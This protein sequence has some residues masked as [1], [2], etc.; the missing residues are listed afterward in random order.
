MAKQRLSMPEKKIVPWKKVVP[1]T[2][3][4]GA[5]IRNN[6]GDRPDQNVNNEVDY[7]K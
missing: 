4:Y 3:Q 6:V 1:H 2:S 7:G 5:R